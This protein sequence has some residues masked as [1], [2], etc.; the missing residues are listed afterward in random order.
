MRQP[1]PPELRAEGLITEI[2][3]YRHEPF[4]DLG[5]SRL[6]GRDVHPGNHGSTDKSKPRR[7][8][9]NPKWLRIHLS[10]TA[11]A[12]GRSKGTHLGAQH[13]RLTGR[14]GYAKANKAV[15]RS[16]LVAAWHVLSNGVPYEDLGEDWFVKRQPEA[17]AHRLAKQI[18]AL[19][20][21][22]ESTP[23]DVLNFGAPSR[24]PGARPSRRELPE[25]SGQ[26]R[27]IL[28]LSSERLTASET[29][30]AARACSAVPCSGD[31]PCSTQSR[32]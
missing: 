3:V 2:S 15:G 27:S 11:S 14:I 18:E 26:T 31:R 8:R 21:S 32:K 13:H 7:A 16:I 25:L 23:T 17:H 19:G 12:A 28:P 29:R 1:E 30:S 4:P 5:A 10:E 20:Y 6:L 24:A 22:D 9:K